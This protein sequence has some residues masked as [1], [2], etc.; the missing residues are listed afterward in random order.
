MALSSAITCVLGIVL[1]T[2]GHG[3][4]GGIFFGIL[5]LVAV[6]AGT[7]VTGSWLHYEHLE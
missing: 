4:A 6:I 5:F 7:V 1:L 2:S 3:S